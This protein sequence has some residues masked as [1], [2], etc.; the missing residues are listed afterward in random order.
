M[1]RFTL[2][3]SCI[4]FLSTGFSNAQSHAKFG[5]IDTRQ[6]VL[7]LPEMKTADSSL[8]KFSASLESQ[9]KTMYTEYQAKVADFKANEATMAEPVKQTKAKEVEDLEQRIRQFQEDAETS[10]QKKEQELLAP[11]SKKVED[12]IKSIAKEKGYGY[13]F[14]MSRGSVIYAQESDDIMPM[15]KAKLGLK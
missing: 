2:I 4:V 12:A 11:I 14:D 3:V 5:H 9:L 15:V 7:M 10:V 1:K 6:L 13:I 8:Q